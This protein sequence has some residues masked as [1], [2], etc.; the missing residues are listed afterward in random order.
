MTASRSLRSSG[1]SRGDIDFTS[2]FELS[3][4]PMGLATLVTEGPDHPVDLR[5]EAVNRAFEAL[6][7]LNAGHL[8]G[9]QA[10]TLWPGL[11]AHWTLRAARV[12]ATGEPAR[13][14]TYARDL[15]QWLEV[16]AFRHRADG[17]AFTLLD[18]TAREEA[19]RAHREAERRLRTFFEMGAVKL[20]IEVPSGR[21]LEANAR[22]VEFYGW[23]LA[24]LKGLNIDQINCLPPED[25]RAEMNLARTQRRNYFNFRH[26]L[27]SGEEREVEVHSAPG[28]WGGREALFSIVFD[29][30]D[31]RLFQRQAVRNER[32]TA[33]GELTAS[34][35]H[36]L[37]NHLG[38]LYGQFQAL[39][40]PGRADQDPAEALGRV[41]VQFDRL[42][43]LLTS[44]RRYL[45]GQELSMGRT[46]LGRL[47]GDVLELMAPLLRTKG[48]ALTFEGA[49][50]D[51]VQA[52]AVL[53]RQVFLNVL[54]NAVQAL[55]ETPE[56]AIAVRIVRVA[57]GWQ[58][59]VANNG[60]PIPDP[61][62]ARLFFAGTSSKDRAPDAGL[63]LGLYLCRSI[64]RSHG[65]DIVL[66]EGSTVAFRITLPSA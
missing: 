17:V 5:F 43:T 12:L 62:R 20:V 26:R 42:K 10:R 50:G 4:Q 40:T 58:A 55:A 23:P 27:A 63:G 45:Q 31:T 35:F 32:L 49:E 60:P 61:V 11:R 56:P 65:G 9:H 21:I 30:T 37:G 24:D 14:V 57:E 3:P 7:G 25:V 2:L 64:L 28:P 59:S 54:I 1:S 38:A 39:A 34:L 22:A 66:A 19:Q 41:E 44:L 33:V 48:I 47:V 29:V 16:T 15:R 53:L 52:D 6:V 18:V 51:E 46:G 13:F 8:L 36:E